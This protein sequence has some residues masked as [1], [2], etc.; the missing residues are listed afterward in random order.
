MSPHEGH[1]HYVI[2]IRWCI[3]W[4]TM[5]GLEEVQ[6]K[7]GLMPLL[8]HE[9]ADGSM[10]QPTTVAVARSNESCCARDGQAKTL[11]ART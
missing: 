8:A 6:A 1:D 2:I 5:N 4:I 9:S 3:Q 11:S 7:E 10:V